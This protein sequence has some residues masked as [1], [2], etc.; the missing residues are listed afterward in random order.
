MKPAGHKMILASA[1]SGKTYAL[2][3]RYVWLL[4]RGAR[5]DRI[6]ALTFTR[7]AAGEFFDEILKKLARA[8]AEPGEAEKIAGQIGMPGLTTRD[9]GRM[10][11]AVIDTMH[12]LSLG[13]LD[14]FFARVVRA[15]PL[16]LGLGGDFE[17]LQE[18]AARLER[19]RVLRRMF[20]R[21]GGVSDAA[22]RDFI[23]AFKRATFGAEEKRLGA[24]LDIFLND[25]AGVL[26]AA[27]DAAAWGERRRIWP[28]GNPW[29]EGKVDL[30]R[31]A[32]ALRAWA[33][34]AGIG[35][36]QRARWDAFVGALATWEPGAKPPARLVYV[37]E[38]ALES[39]RGL[40]K[41][42]AVLAFDRRFQELSPPACA[43][44]ADIVRHVV[45]GELERR[46]QMTRGVH[47]VLQAYE[48]VYD[49]AVR[50]AGRLTFMD[51]QRLLQP[52]AAGGAPPLSRQPAAAD[53]ARL[54]IDW[55]L[56]AQ[57]DHWLLDEFQDTSFGQ[58]NV[59]RNLVDEA[60][61]DAE[62]TRSFFYVGDVKQAIFAWRGGDARLF[63]EIFD[64]YNA[65][66]PGTIVEE[67][68]AV[69]FRSGPAVIATV[70]RVFSDAE[71]LRR[72]FPPA[73]A[74]RWSAEWEDHTSA[75]PGMGG[76]AE[77]R[78]GADEA[79][80]FAQTLR[81]LEETRALAR[82]FGVA[83]LVRTNDTAIDLAD[84]LRREGGL[85]AVAEADLAVGVDNPLTSVLLALCRAA[86]H[87]GDGAAWEHLRMTP[88][89]SVLAEI[90][91]DRPDAL[92]T[93]VLGEIH[94][95]GFE[96][97][98]EGWLRRLEP[99][100]A[101]DDAFSRERGREFAA[102]A[103]LF[104][105]TGS[106]EVAEFVQFME[107]YAVRDTDSSSV[108][109]VMTVHK[110]KG[111]GFDLVILP[112]LE[113]NT[114]AERR[115]GLA[116]Q[117]RPDRSVEW[118]LQLPGEEFLTQDPVLSQYV[119]AA[120]A[121]G[122][123]ENFCLLYV[124]M[125]RAKS[126]LYIVTEPVGTSRSL[127][128]PR[129]LQETLGESWAAGDPL[130]F[131][132]RGQVDVGSAGV[133]PAVVDLAGGDACAT[134][135]AIPPCGIAS[136]FLPVLDSAR[137]TGALRRPG[138]RPSEEKAG[139]IPAAKIFA[140]EGKAAADFGSAVHRLL[141]G[142]E[143]ADATDTQKFAAWSA[144][145]AE[146][147]EALACLQAPELAG[148]WRRPDGSGETGEV[149]RER[150]FEVVLDGAWVTGAFDRVVV[151]RDASRRAVRAAVFDFKTDRLA[152]E[153]EVAEAP[154][155][156]AGQLDLYRRAAAML[157]GL[158]VSAVDGEVVF[159]HA[160]RRVP[161]AEE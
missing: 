76:Y 56:D 153:T 26:L 73:A 47:E 45:G 158:P 11:R 147:A 8:A 123:Y 133:P 135:D 145:G 161:V 102:A 66:A 139:M 112:D 154:R 107:H 150:A 141:A 30:E 119:D 3:N 116:V 59:L 87:P 5:P 41:G 6:A 84:F 78:Q 51:L 29:L 2:T 57:I 99:K 62:G 53:D 42:N 38:K 138:R 136:T 132:G 40:L 28:G 70:N 82:G 72:L 100:L 103:R 50:R 13:T 127:N 27:P 86:A 18:H 37:L 77:L 143:W 49:G 55:R 22:H 134:S 155:R 64:H 36:K 108:V 24:L 144:R 98:A 81:I 20:A 129:L 92:T 95:A 126:A 54:F 94:A 10:L 1:G 96:A 159:T 110:A 113:G 125:T 120:R 17:I 67:R 52:A 104:D 12:R 34:E 35:E 88:L 93:Q 128:F 157:T 131:E 80:R 122:C 89:G 117:K 118:V 39:W 106:R 69:S 85:P 91:L 32:T 115:K 74:A 83:V 63:R 14:S 105:E 44:L 111:L 65:G 31:A 9:F 48:Q 114:L 15:F 19:R 33:G 4:A 43:A 25:Y 21:A 151:V 46:L 79:E 146:G 156:Y 61:Q 58:W 90:G 124:A 97:M 160:R 68:L 101:A 16:E 130:W 71:A 109:R 148:V 75:N 60:V 140:L 121:D 152:G 7:K 142:V 23:E 137:P 149:W